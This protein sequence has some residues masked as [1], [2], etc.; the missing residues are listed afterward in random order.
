MSKVSS[1]ETFILTVPREVPYLGPLGAGERV[2]SRGY[3]VRKGNGTLYPTVDRS[4]VVRLT[5]EDGA[6]GWGETYGICAPR[7]VCE[8]VH[9]LLAPELIG[10]EPEDVER[11]WDDLYGLMRVRGCFGGF[12]VDAI[13]AL[14]IALWDLRARARQVPLWQLLGT[15]QRERI[16]GYVS[17]LPTATLEGKVAMAREFHAAGHDALKVHAVV[18]HDGIVEEM[19]ALRD[20]LGPGPQLMV[21]LHWKFDGAQALALAEQLAP[22]ALTFIEAPL[23]PEDVAGLIE[24]GQRSPIAIA[25]GE[26]WHTEYEARLRLAGGTLSYI[27][28]EMG[29]TGITQFMRIA[30]LA[31]AHGVQIAP[32]ATIGGGLFMAASLHAASVVAPLWRHEWQHSIFSRSLEMLDTDMAYRDGYYQLPSGPGL[33]ATPGPR[34]WEHA[35]AVD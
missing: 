18:S 1:V 10:R 27:Q 8:I 11:V 28:P 2:N 7:A 25:A 24:L 21:D 13:A 5:T 9:D 33:G 20:A 30:R 35:E 14:D 3:L 31:Q 26:E 32:H 17:G 22:C 16:P 12:H 34:F 4:L 15:R 23:K 19:R 29:H 6:V